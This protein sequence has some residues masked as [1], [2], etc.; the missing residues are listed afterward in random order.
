M[1]VP[2]GDVW[3]DLLTTQRRELGGLAHQRVVAVFVDARTRILGDAVIANGTLS[4][5]AFSAREVAYHA[6]NCRASGVI[7]FHGRPDGALNLSDDMRDL[8]REHSS[9]LAGVEIALLDYVFVNQNG[10]VSARDVGA[11]R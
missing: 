4:E 6:F 1:G 3:F 7:L 8:L 5:C 10:T 2:Y 11:L 9:K